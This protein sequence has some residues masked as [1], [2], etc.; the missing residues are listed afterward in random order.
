MF[1]SA[2][3]DVAVLAVLGIMATILSMVVQAT[4]V[5]STVLYFVIPSVYLGY[6]LRHRAQWRR[7]AAMTIVFGVLYGFFF[8]YIAEWNGAWAWPP[9]SILGEKLWFSVVNPAAVLWLM[10]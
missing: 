8:T 9:E 7:I 5:L 1:R 4:F 2:A 10:L 3:F 6:R